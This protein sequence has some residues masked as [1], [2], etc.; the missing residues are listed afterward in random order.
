MKNW[1]RS[2]LL[3]TTS[4]ATVAALAR[5]D[6]LTPAGGATV[7]RI[8][9]GTICKECM[10][11][12]TTAEGLLEVNLERSELEDAWEGGVCLALLRERTHAVSAALL[13]ADLEHVLG[14]PVT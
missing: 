3:R 2:G 8:A 5:G 12:S 6:V 9:L 13:V 7:A 1:C 10:R 14:C 4:A 11:A